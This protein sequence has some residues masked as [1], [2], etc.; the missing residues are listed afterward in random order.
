M[1]TKRYSP[2]VAK[3]KLK[4]VKM[5]STIDENVQE[6]IRDEWLKLPNNVT[7]RISN[8]FEQCSHFRPSLLCSSTIKGVI[9]NFFKWVTNPFNGRQVT[10]KAKLGSTKG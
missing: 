2:N 3:A 7:Q 8:V 4:M 9:I 1:F 5:F 10:P 6:F